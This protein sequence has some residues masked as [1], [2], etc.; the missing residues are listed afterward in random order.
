MAE[1]EKLDL[2]E[3]KPKS[4]KKTLL[5]IIVVAAV[6]FLAVAAV[7][8]SLYS[9]GI[10]TS[11]KPKEEKAGQDKAARV[12]KGAEQKPMVYLPLSPPFA[13]N[14]KNNPEARMVQI[15]LTVAA[16]DPVVI[17]AIKKHG[18]MLRNNLLLLLSGED[19]AVLSTKEG[20]NALRAKVKEEIKKVV[21]RQTDR[22][23]GVDEV[24]FTGFVMQ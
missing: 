5:I 24:F 23:E 15:D 21:I 16:T 14:F 18:P 6:V 17:E 22:K 11:S 8:T 4:S 19:P 3:E 10:F 2:G 9:F 7:T 13:A 20:K 12:E 1:K